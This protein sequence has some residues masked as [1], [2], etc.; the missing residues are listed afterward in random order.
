VSYTLLQL[1]ASSAS[2][3]SSKKEQRMEIQT[4][5]SIASA[6]PT[7]KRYSSKQK[8]SDSQF[9][10][11]AAIIKTWISSSL[12]HACLDTTPPLSW[13]IALTNKYKDSEWDLCMRDIFSAMKLPFRQSYPIYEAISD[14]DSFIYKL[15]NPLPSDLEFSRERLAAL[16]LEASRPL[17][18]EMLIKIGRA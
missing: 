9:T 17:T 16:Q 11:I 15:L 3:A 4:L 6:M 10:Q 1:L 14:L 12:K 7:V 8:I 2:Y 18:K 13:Q 5:F